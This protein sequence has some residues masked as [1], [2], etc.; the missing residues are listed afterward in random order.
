MGSRNRIVGFPGASAFRD[1]HGKIR[2]RYRK[3]G[4]P[5]VYLPGLPGSPEFAEAYAAAVAGQ[6]RGAGEKRTKPGSINALAVM[7][8]ASAEWEALGKATRV[9][10]RGIIERMRKDYGDLPVRGLNPTHVYA[11]RDK[12]KATPATANNFLKVL[13]FM[14]AFAVSRQLRTDNP[15]AMVKPIK[16]ESAGFHTWSEAEIARFEERWKVGTRERL[17]FDLLLYTAQR[18]GDVRQMGRQHLDGDAIFVRQQKTGAELTIPIHPRLAASLATVPAG[19]M[20]FI[21]TTAGA[22]YTAAGFGNWFRDA[23]REAGL[24]RCSAHGLRKS[25][26]TRL[27][28]AGCSEAQIMAVTG[29]AT[30]NEVRRYTA[31]RDQRRL[32]ASALASIGGTESE[33][34]LAN[35][36]TRLAKSAG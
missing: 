4:R 10:Y 16:I 17:A 14:M 31:A 36:D 11:I 33:Q 5:T 28:D 25:A 22:A 6:G 8:Y 12:L 19:Q 18:S 2:W 35:P 32:A 3:R 23:C 21:Q 26:A 29:H 9:T 30:S 13:R 34:K 24:T 27:A 7:V 1:R 20:L 15:A